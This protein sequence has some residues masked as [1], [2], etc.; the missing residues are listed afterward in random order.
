[1]NIQLPSFLFPFSRVKFFLPGYI[2]N[3][4]DA[5]L[6]KLAASDTPVSCHLS[7]PQQARTNPS[8]TYIVTVEIRD[9]SL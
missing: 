9:A 5:C 1:M 2:C 6:P 8:W 7:E 4:F 3:H